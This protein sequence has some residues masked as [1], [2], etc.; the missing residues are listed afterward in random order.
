MRAFEISKTTL[1]LI[2]K[3]CYEEYFDGK[4]RTRIIILFEF[5]ASH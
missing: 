3:T 2:K 1:T 5:I 4:F